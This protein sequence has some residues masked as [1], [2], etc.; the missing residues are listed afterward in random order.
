MPSETVEIVHSP[1]YSG[2]VLLFKRYGF[3]MHEGLY[4]N[5]N[6][7]ICKEEDLDNFHSLY[8]DQWDWEKDY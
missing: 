8:V 1:R 2:N 3:G 4:T 6:A 5:M 7:A